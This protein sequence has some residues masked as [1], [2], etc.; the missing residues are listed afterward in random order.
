[1]T[2][3]ELPSPELLR[4]LLRYEP[5]TGKLFWLPRGLEFFKDARNW[6]RWTTLFSGKEA[7]AVRSNDD[8]FRGKILGCEIKAHRVIW[9]MQTG[10]WPENQIDHID[11]NGLN[12]VWI[13]LRTATQSQNNA[14]KRRQEKCSSLYRGVCWAKRERQWV[15]SIKKDKKNCF[16]GYFS[17]EKMAAQAYDQAAK[18]VHGEF[19]NLNF[20]ER[21][22][23]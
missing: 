4:K 17:D 16:L 8:Y 3:K 22:A 14:N 11:H 21:E 18:R 23:Q 12:N 10:A 2:A 6:K 13:N 19:A 1:M 20:P 15:A 9:A 7:F 5:E